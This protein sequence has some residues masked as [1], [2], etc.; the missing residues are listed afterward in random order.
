MLGRAKVYFSQFFT[1][2]DLT[3]C[4]DGMYLSDRKRH[5][6]KVYFASEMLVCVELGSNLPR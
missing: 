2:I 3:F 5:G 4:G 6:Q 1:E